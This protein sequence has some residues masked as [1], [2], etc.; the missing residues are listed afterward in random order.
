IENIQNQAEVENTPAFSFTQEMIDKALQGGTGHQNGKFRVY[1]LYQE[2]FSSKE[3]QNFLKKEFNYYG[4]NGVT[5]LNGIWVEYSPSKGLK[6]SKRDVE[7]TMQINWN[8]IEKR[9][10][11][12]ISLDRF[13]T[14]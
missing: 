6:L 10:G 12:L 1:R 8:T 13:F 4:T 7:N 9:I 3:R 2:T 14:G 5:G 11:E